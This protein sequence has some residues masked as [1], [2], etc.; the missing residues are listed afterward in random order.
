MARIDSGFVG[1]TGSAL[2]NDEKRPRP[3]LL[4]DVGVDGEDRIAGQ[5]RAEQE[6][7][8]ERG[9]VGRND[10]LAAAPRARARVPRPRPDTAPRSTSRT[11]AF[12]IVAAQNPCGHHRD[13]N[14]REAAQREQRAHRQSTRGQHGRGHGGQRH[15]EGVDDVVGGDDARPIA[16][17]A[18]VLQQRIQRNAEQ[19]AGHRQ[20]D[21]IARGRAS[22]PASPRNAADAG[23]FSARQRGRRSRSADRPRRAPSPA[24]RTARAA[25]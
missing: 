5:E 6:P 20:A 9:V 12:A 2:T 15:R 21:K 8:E 22:F 17:F 25:R 18:L 11:H 7:I 14:R 1:S 3:P 23:K 19:A 4:R 13:R 10:R 24:P 16:R